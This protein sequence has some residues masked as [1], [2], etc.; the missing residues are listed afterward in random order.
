M[1]RR[2][3]LVREVLWADGPTYIPRLLGL[4]MIIVVLLLPWI[5]AW[6]GSLTL[7][8]LYVGYEKTIW[9]INF[10]VEY[11]GQ[12][13]AAL[14]LLAALI[15]LPFAIWW[16]LTNKPVI[17]GILSMTS[18]ALLM[19]EVTQ[20]T[21]MLQYLMREWRLGEPF[22]ISVGTYGIMVIGFLLLFSYYQYRRSEM[23]E[24]ET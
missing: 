21:D 6:N 3:G 20:A 1:M 7:I 17:S 18:G 5:T 15:M 16:A 4:M 10:T 9:W 19:F 22:N 14:A 23:K 8:N 12:V 11:Y 13:D 24:I 2:L